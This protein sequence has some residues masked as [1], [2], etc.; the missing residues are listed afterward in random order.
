MLHQRH[1]STAPAMDM[2]L[3]IISTGPLVSGLAFA[4]LA[5]GMYL[6]ASRSGQRG[7]AAAA[8]VFAY[9]AFALLLKSLLFVFWMTGGS[10][11]ES[12]SRLTYFLLEWP[13]PFALLVASG[14]FLFALDQERAAGDRA[15]GA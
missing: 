2:N 4:G 12:T 1:E 8:I 14:C 3:R 15:D 5:F 9:C 6:L 11:A 13:R 10:P 7:Y